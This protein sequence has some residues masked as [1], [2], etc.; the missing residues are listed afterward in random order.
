M[1]ATQRWRSEPNLNALLS[2]HRRFGLPDSTGCHHPLRVGGVGGVGRIGGDAP[3]Q[4]P[5][6]KEVYSKSANL[7]SIT[8]N[9]QVQISADSKYGVALAST[10]WLKKSL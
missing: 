9:L 10:E 1:V 5:R 8:G 7:G 2:F 3:D 6:P 4:R